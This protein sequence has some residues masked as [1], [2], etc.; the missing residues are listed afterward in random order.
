MKFS[1]PSSVLGIL[2]RAAL[3]YACGLGVAVAL[4]VQ[5]LGGCA[6][7]L[8][9]VVGVPTTSALVRY[10]SDRKAQRRDDRAA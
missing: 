3:A 8:A 10:F 2:A 4:H 1:R 9:F 6:I 7:M 5:R